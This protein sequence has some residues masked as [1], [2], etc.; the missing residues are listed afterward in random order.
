MFLSKIDYFG[1]HP[2][3]SSFGSRSYKSLTGSL[4]S[5]AVFAVI[6]VATF[7]FGKDFYLKETPRVFTE[8]IISD[9]YDNKTV[10]STNFNYIFRIEDEDGNY[11]ENVSTFLKFEV[12]YSIMTYNMSTMKFDSDYRY[13]EPKT[14]TN[15]SVSDGELINNRNLSEWLCLDFG[16]EGASFGGSWSGDFVY[17]WELDLKNCDSH[18]NCFNANITKQQVD[19]QQIYFSMFYPTYYFS[20]GNFTSPLNIKYKNYYTKL[21]GSIGLTERLFFKSYYMSDDQGWIFQDIV[22]S[23]IIGF[24]TIERNIKVVENEEEAIFYSLNLYFNSDK[25]TIHRS[26][27]KIQE[28]AA[29]VGGFMKIIIF[30][31]EIIVVPYNL[32]C[33]NERLMNIIVTKSKKFNDGRKLNQVR[34]DLKADLCPCLT[35]EEKIINSRQE[36]PKLLYKNTNN[37]HKSR[38]ELQ[39][40]IDKSTLDDDNF[41]KSRIT[42]LSK[43]QFNI[44]FIK[45]LWSFLC[46]NRSP[47]FLK[48]QQA[49][50]Y[51]KSKL[52]ISAFIRNFK[53][54]DSLK[55]LSLNHYQAA[56]L[57]FVRNP[58]VNIEEDSH[59]F[60]NFAEKHSNGK[61]EELV[62]YFLG[63]KRIGELDK[64]D[65]K[66]LSKLD[67]SVYEIISLG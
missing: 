1:A 44:S 55:H 38:S 47:Q 52:D 5:I 26:Y 50:N 40:I 39:A 67:P 30:A 11:V 60:T 24:D 64:T 23:S 25:L 51:L 14:C 13:Y 56:A 20:P 21:Y 43:D 35:S 33:L 4:F 12:R 18:Q 48:Y 16:P 37:I 63:F 22:P 6:I 36:Q 2:Q 49:K 27:M 3:L 9:T 65:I 19:A 31:A 8:S 17:Y 46:R 34:K 53:Q 45:Y 28:L 42:R 62:K 58:S 59:H 41:I 10:N 61:V 57:D 7:L 66:I 15:K 29:L 32:F 54:L